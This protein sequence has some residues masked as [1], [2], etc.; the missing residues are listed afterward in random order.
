MGGLQFGMSLFGGMSKHNE[1]VR[2]AE[3]QYAANVYQNTF[4]NLMIQR[5]NELTEKRFDKQL[6]I[7][8]RQVQLQC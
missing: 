5:Q 8:D 3:Q 7:A 1:A 4:Q 2:Q 6:E